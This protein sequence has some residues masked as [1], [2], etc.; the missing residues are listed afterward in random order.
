MIS[1]VYDHHWKKLP[2]QI[3]KKNALKNNVKF[4]K[5]NPIVMELILAKKQAKVYL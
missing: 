4:Q 3:L 2:R 1:R 5:K